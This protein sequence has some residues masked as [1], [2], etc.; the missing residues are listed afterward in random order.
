MNKEYKTQYRVIYADTDQMGCVYYANYLKIFETGRN[1]T[2]RQ[3][4]LTYKK[5]EDI[6][7]CFPAVHAELDYLSPARYD[8]LLDVITT[9]SVSPN[10]K[11]KFQMHCKIYNQDEK[12]LVEGF[13]E[14]VWTDLTGKPLRPKTEE[15]KEV[16]KKLTESF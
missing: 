12:L 3:I 5:I 1:E 11:L 6:G 2:L 16:Y 10:S 4:G 15:Q 7:I 9:C 13:T 14:H 8:D